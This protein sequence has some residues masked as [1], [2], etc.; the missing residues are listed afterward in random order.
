MK[1]L[2]YSHNF[3]ENAIEAK[4]VEPL[5]DFLE[6]LEF[7]ILAGTSKRLRQTVEEELQ[8]YGWSDKVKIH[9]EKDLTITSMKK[10]IGLC[11]QT[12]N[13]SRFYADLLKLQALF[14]KD[15]IKA[16]IYIIPSKEASK[17]LGSNI[18]NADRFIDELSIFKHIITIPI[19]VISI[20]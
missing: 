17:K 6:S 2:N 3:G 20:S 4:I 7:P 18:A 10:N 16:A 14:L 8:N 13:V 1:V 19:L 12:G 11:I 15:K 5:I 9:Y